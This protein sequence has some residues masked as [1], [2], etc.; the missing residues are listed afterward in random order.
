MT[1][2]SL[3]VAAL[4]GAALIMTVVPVTGAAEL[5][6]VDTFVR[7][8]TDTTFA[9]Y[10]A[11]GAFGTL[12]HIRQP[13]PLDKQDVIRM[14][15]DTL[16]SAGLFDLTTPVTIIKPETGGRFQSMLVIN[17]DHSML[18]VEHGP[19]EF[20]FSRETIGTRYVMIVFRTFVDAGHPDDIKAANALQDRIGF[21]QAARGEFTVPAWDPVSLKKMRDAIN[22]LAATLPDFRGCF[23]NKAKL[24]PVRHLLGTAYGWGGNPDAAAQYAN[25][26][27]ADNDGRTPHVLTVR[28][29]PV[30]GFWSITVYNRDGFMEPN[31]Q[32]AY[33]FNN[34]T[35]RKNPDGSITIHFGAGPE[36]INNLPVT[37]GWNYTVRMYEPR[38]EILEGTWSFPQATPMR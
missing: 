9:R 19:G 25:V 36:A 30:N 3:S 38:A 15:R 8:E 32:G 23:G 13:V 6:T 21:R 14:N 26:T 7:A 16:Y 10:A 35:A 12:F 1:P 18:P 5:V 37:P 17:Q 29:V 33:S 31:A 27:P 24:D 28:D 20:T 2:I 22:V 11:Q 34:V 4:L